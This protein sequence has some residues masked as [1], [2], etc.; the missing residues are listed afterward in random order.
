MMMGLIIPAALTSQH[1]CAVLVHARL[2]GPA[3]PDVV[4]DVAVLRDHSQDGY[5]CFVGLRPLYDRLAQRTA[6]RD[7]V[8]ESRN[9]QRA[10]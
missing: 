6:F 2:E 1:R 4:L 7:D 10:S 9:T 8:R 5:R 3:S